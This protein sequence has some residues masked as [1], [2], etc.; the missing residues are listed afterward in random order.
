MA[1]KEQEKAIIDAN[2]LLKDA[3][4]TDNIQICINLSKQHN[5]VNFNLKESGILHPKKP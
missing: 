3:W 5:N 2:A 1:T 4:P